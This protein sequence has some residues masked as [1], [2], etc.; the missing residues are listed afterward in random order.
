MPMDG[1][2][3]VQPK[4]FKESLSQLIASLITLSKPMAKNNM[5]TSKYML[6]YPIQKLQKNKLEQPSKKTMNRLTFSLSDYIPI[7]IWRNI[8]LERLMWITQLLLL[9]NHLLIS[10]SDNFFLIFFAQLKF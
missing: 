6:I 5:K 10:N 4:S 3:G 7:M 9:H 1:I 8:L 2:E